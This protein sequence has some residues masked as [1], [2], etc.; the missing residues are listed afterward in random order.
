MSN[1][2]S[3]VDTV[4]LYRRGATVRRRVVLG[5]E[6]PTELEVPGLPLA[7][8]DP[9]ARV[10]VVSID[11]PPGSDVV[12][13]SL[14]IGLWAAPRETPPAPPEEAELRRLEGD[15]ARDEA[16]V[17]ALRSELALLGE[18][19]IPDRPQAEEGRPPPRSPLVA[20][21]AL[22]ELVDEGVRTR[23]EAIEA[24]E[25]AL[26]VHRE[27]LADAQARRQRASSARVVSPAELK[28]TVIIGL[29]WSGP[30]ARAVTLE[31]E[32]FVPGARWVPAYQCRMSRDGR[33]TTLALRALVCQRSG[34][35]WSAA[36]LELSTAAPLRWT[37]IPELPSLRI[38]KAQA[39]PAGRRGFRPPPVG[40]NVLLDDYDRDVMRLSRPNLEYNRPRLALFAPASP[41][42]PQRP[43]GSAAYGGVAAPE[44]DESWSSSDGTGEIASPSRKSLA[45]PAPAA[46]PARPIAVGAA[47]MSMAA[48]RAPARDMMKEEAAPRASKKAERRSRASDDADDEDQGSVQP[49]E[50]A[51]EAFVF[52][53]LRLRAAW[54]GADR[55]RLIPVD[56]MASYLEILGRTG[57]VV[58]GDA[59]QAL[60]EAAQRAES[61]AAVVLPRG[62]SA[63]RDDRTSFDYAY[64]ADAP[65]DVPSDGA[66]HSV[67]VTT[68]A[69]AS[70]VAFVVVP[71][72]DT[73]VFR[74]ATLRHTG[75]TP[76]LA[77]PVEVYVG[78]E[79][80]LTAEL[81]TVPGGGQFQLGLGVEQAIKCARNARY[82]ESRSG[83]KVV[84]THELMHTL[85]IELANHLDRDVQCEVRERI[86]QPA[87][88]AEV[89]VEEG[90]VVPAWS[91]YS[92]SERGRP[93][94]GGRRWRVSV[95][96]GARVKLTAEYVVKI[97][98]NNEIAGGNRREA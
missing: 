15:I 28:K 54:E 33:E 31:L 27:K 82:S 77:G 81:P 50:A 35:D 69:L 80:V 84:A 1:V 92:Q 87:A 6:R 32:Y 38:G 57:L 86:P 74:V 71:R 72:E 55:G 21:L 23:S 30:E 64:A 85:E 78:D 75:H 58:G 49:D 70:D 46:S 94:A 67:P 59:R 51:L 68:A 8:W 39:S 44:A 66:Y 73:N 83:D 20:R 7:L 61:A 43:E 93:L 65:V 91:S 16:H 36:K 5:A 24:L 62:A 10:R 47:R 53:S 11:G 25:Q 37:E 18:V 52:T 90:R 3:R 56:A 2:E 41:T 97:Y 12:A 17:A 26:R 45:A 96:P 9:T 40:A 42:V 76:F 22:E 13:T 29:V 48:A 98:A 88:N 79:Y 95:A 19:T 89:V 60:I 34:E 14:R 4:R 63:L